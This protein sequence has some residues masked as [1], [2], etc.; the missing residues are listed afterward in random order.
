MVR[1]LL[2]LL[3]IWFVAGPGW[4]QPEQPLPQRIRLLLSTQPD[5]ADVYR[6]PPDSGPAVWLG[7]SDHPLPLDLE[8]GTAEVVLVVE[9]AGYRPTVLRL[10]REE[11]TDGARLG[12]VALPPAHGQALFR[13]AR[14]NL[15]LLL[16][17][18]VVL[19]LHVRTWLGVRRVSKLPAPGPPPSIGPV[20]FSA[21]PV[22]PVDLPLRRRTDVGFVLGFGGVAGALV[23][24][25]VWGGSHLVA[26]VAG[27]LPLSYGWVWKGAVAACLATALMEMW[28]AEPVDLAQYVGERGLARFRFTSRVQAELV[29]FQEVVRVEEQVQPQERDMGYHPVTYRWMTG[30]DQERLQLHD[31]Q[32]AFGF[33][34]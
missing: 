6:V 22:Q 24:A 28:L 9:C 10:P 30:D 33:P 26:S 7:T 18:L 2:F 4:A 14:E 31:V 3:A 29:L 21:H 8:P 25:L 16:G 23:G 5:G 17:W 12:P 32:G 13:L 15:W 19:G 27:T 11:V 20:L 34:A 1:G